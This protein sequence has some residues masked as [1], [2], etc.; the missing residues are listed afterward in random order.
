MKKL[1]TILASIVLTL[2]MSTMRADTTIKILHLQDNPAF[3]ELWKQIGTEF[4]KKNPGVKIDWQFL[5]NEAFKA[6]LPTTLQS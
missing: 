2:A 3:L 1:L 4:E 6:K 5:E